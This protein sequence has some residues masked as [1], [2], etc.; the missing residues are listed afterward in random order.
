MTMIHSDRTVAA[1][2]PVLLL[3]E[4]VKSRICVV[5]LA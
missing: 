4:P 3:E 2:R 1:P 5:T